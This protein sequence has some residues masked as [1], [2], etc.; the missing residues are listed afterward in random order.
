MMQVRK[1]EQEKGIRWEDRYFFSP[2]SMDEYLHIVVKQYRHL[3]KNNF[4]GQ[5]SLPMSYFYGHDCKDEWHTLLKR[6]SRS[7]VTGQIRI[8]GSLVTTKTKSTPSATA[9]LHQDKNLVSPSTE[10][11]GGEEEEERASKEQM[12]E[13]QTNTRYENDILSGTAKLFTHLTRGG[14]ALTHSNLHC[15]EQKA[16]PE[17]GAE[18][19]KQTERFNTTSSTEQHKR[20]HKACEEEKKEIEEKQDEE[21]ALLERINKERNI[22]LEKEIKNLQ[23]IFAMDDDDENA[24]TCVEA[25]EWN[26]EQRTLLLSLGTST[27]NEP[28]Q[29]KPRFC[30]AIHVPDRYP[31]ERPSVT[32]VPSSSSGS[33]S[34]RAA[35]L[36][37]EFLRHG[38]R[39][40]SQR[41]IAL[42]DIVHF[43]IINYDKR[44][45]NNNMLSSSFVTSNSS[46][47]ERRRR[48]AKGSLMF[49]TM[50]NL[51]ASSLGTPLSRKDKEERKDE[52]DEDD[53]EEEECIL[54][55]RSKL[56]SPKSSVL[57]SPARSKGA[58]EDEEAE[59]ED[60]DDGSYSLFIVRDEDDL[61]EQHVYQV[62]QIFGYNSIT[63]LRESNEV[64]LFLDVSWM[65]AATADALGICQNQPIAITLSF[66]G[67]YFSQQD[68]S[69]ASTPP[70]PPLI[71]VSQTTSLKKEFGMK[72]Q[73]QQIIRRFLNKAW[74]AF[75]FS[76]MESSAKNNG[77]EEENRF[78]SSFLEKEKEQKSLLKKTR[79][80]RFLLDNGY[81]QLNSAYALD[82]EENN[83]W[84]AKA[85][86][87]SAT[88]SPSST[89]ALQDAEK[90]ETRK[91]E[92]QDASVQHLLNKFC[93]NNERASANLLATLMC[94]VILRL[95]NCMDHC[96]VCDRKLPFSGL[97]PVTCAREECL[98]RLT[99]LGLGSSS[100]SS[101]LN[102]DLHYVDLMISIASA[103]AQSERWP[104]L[105]APF[106][107]DFLLPTT[108]EENETAIKDKEEDPKRGKDIEALRKVLQLTPSV[109]EMRDMATQNG[110]QGLRQ[111]L[112]QEKHP[113][114]Y[115]L[116]RW[117]LSTNRSHL[118]KI[119][120][121]GF[122]DQMQTPHQFVL[123]CKTP[124]KEAKF[125]AL[126]KK[127]GSVWAFHGSALENWHAILRV[128]LQNMTNT[129]LMSK[130]AVF[131]AGI[132]LSPSINTSRLYCPCSAVPW[133]QTIL[134][135]GSFHAIALCE[136]V[137]HPSLEGQP[138]PHYVVQNEH[139]VTTRYFF[140]YKAST[141]PFGIDLRHQKDLCQRLSGYL[142][143][144]STGQCNT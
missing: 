74:P 95:R 8:R 14:I 129:A 112:E 3:S 47:E 46:S 97:K 142:S 65:N 80:I 12:T 18:Q 105:L 71:E 22:R 125:Q 25:L 116:L 103:A 78:G 81:D 26:R 89:P 17:Q 61:L 2:K 76:N 133:P 72:T 127:Y 27:T 34:R 28:A 64:V 122:I 93:S 144:T 86:M 100:I 141:I 67:Y 101:Q 30:F 70:P 79:G 123:L 48:L 24:N 118:R 15:N 131:G 126:K 104:Y 23:Q 114:L 20:E 41:F 60:E 33:S 92:L 7:K 49:M 56:W 124:E 117:I 132:Y 121:N 43:F 84:K 99:E 38:N 63:Y 59:E 10:R 77:K 32:L 5:L 98:F 130:G 140:V 108:K 135:N 6:S 113:L 87:E 106:P 85:R 16:E 91:N 11:K 88:N 102:H 13:E 110:E 120:E 111:K 58:D 139:L 115:R 73:L 44:C 39:Y 90:E 109:E 68:D 119:P 52:E 35:A 29:T 21:R 137:K 57:F 128:G 136:I 138:N 82:K 75:F 31:R 69:K 36:G 4:L 45:N 1:E 143:H 66:I 62:Q 53:D 134:G 54:I 107:T 94:Y 37:Q 9:V 40:A 55:Q 83:P 42:L 19:K 96:V 50:A 51:W